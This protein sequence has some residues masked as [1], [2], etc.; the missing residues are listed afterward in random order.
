MHLR[1]SNRSEPPTI[2]ATARA[3]A[4]VAAILGAATALGLGCGANR[5]HTLEVPV[6][7]D[8]GVHGIA[9][10]PLSELPHATDSVR[11][12]DRVATLRSPLGTEAVAALIRRV[13]ESFRAR[14]TA[15]M[16]P[17]LDESI[18]DLLVDGEARSRYAV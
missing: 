5:L 3:R 13:F 11:D 18:V 2:L 9:V 15:S 10:D 1:R 6:D 4:L 8:A 14:T 7:D 17:D 12:G 16:E